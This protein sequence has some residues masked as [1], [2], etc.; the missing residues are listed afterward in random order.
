MYLCIVFT[1]D[2]SAI[3]DVDLHRVRLFRDQS[4]FAKARAVIEKYDCGRRPVRFPARKWCRC[5]RYT[6]GRALT[7]P[8]L[9]GKCEWFQ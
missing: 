8:L 9:N 5:V 6:G 3:T 7:S 1:P 4:D 2:V